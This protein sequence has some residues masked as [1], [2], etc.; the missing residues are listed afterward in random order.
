MFLVNREVLPKSYVTVDGAD[1][2]LLA[3]SETV[4]TRDHGYGA[5]VGLL[6]IVSVH[7]TAL[8]VPAHGGMRG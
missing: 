1:L 2:Y 8:T 6:H 7:P 4:T 5:S 3:L